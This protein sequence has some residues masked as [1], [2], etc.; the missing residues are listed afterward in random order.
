MR[1]GDTNMVTDNPVILKNTLNPPTIVCMQRNAEKK[2]PT[3]E[4]IIAANK[5]G[6]NDEIGVV[7]NHV[8]SMFEVQAG[9]EKDSKEYKELE[10]RIMSGQFFQQNTID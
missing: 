4:D 8:T 5:L 9:Y 1:L 3:E 6:F 7:T 2:V 10:Y